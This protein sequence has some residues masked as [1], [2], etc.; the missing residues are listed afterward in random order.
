MISSLIA[1]TAPIFMVIAAPQGFETKDPEPPVGDQTLKEKLA[2]YDTK[3]IELWKKVVESDWNYQMNFSNE[4][5]ENDK[6]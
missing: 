3:T 5:L 2:I 4:I 6:V 1:I